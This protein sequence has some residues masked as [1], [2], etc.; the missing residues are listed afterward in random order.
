MGTINSKIEPPPEIFLPNPLIG[1]V[2]DKVTAWGCFRTGLPDRGKQFNLFLC[3]K[4]GFMSWVPAGFPDCVWQAKVDD[5]HSFPQNGLT[6][7]RFN[8]DMPTERKNA[9]SA[10]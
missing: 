6:L 9:I 5:Q 4:N 10:S 1:P 7:Q 2:M 8:D 3:E